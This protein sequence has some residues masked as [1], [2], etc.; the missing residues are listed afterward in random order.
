MKIIF[1]DVDGVLN[2][3]MYEA[4]RNDDCGDGYIDLSRVKL[5]ADIVNATGAK[6]VLT[7]S[8]RLEW[9]KDSKRCGSDG[10]YI[11]Q[12]FAKYGLSIMDKTL[13]TSFF[14]ERR[15]E[16]LSW[17]S[18][19]R[20]E[21]ESFVI[22]DDMN[23]GWGELSGRVVITDPLSYGLEEEHVQKALELL[24]TQIEFGQLESE[25]TSF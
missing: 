3:E 15:K 22:L 18:N 20:S 8:L 19:H 13:F 2:S 9:E 25:N 5:L 7:S 23:Y 10:K 17:I 6:I 24:S 4:S 21:V 12:C 1:L 11:N 16:I 14:A